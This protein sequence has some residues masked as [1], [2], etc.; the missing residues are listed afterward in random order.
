[1]CLYHQTTVSVPPTS[2]K[3]A[4][5]LLPCSAS[6]SEPER[7]FLISQVNYLDVK[8]NKVKEYMDNTNTT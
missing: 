3:H 2:S 6:D 5:S 1:M 8:T 4:F 7:Q